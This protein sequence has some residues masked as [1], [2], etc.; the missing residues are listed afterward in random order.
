MLNVNQKKAL[1]EMLAPGSRTADEVA[2]AA[3]LSV[4][5]VYNY[6]ANDEFRAALDQRLDHSIS[7]ATV[8]LTQLSEKAINAL[9]EI[10]D[11]K[12]ASDTNK[13]LAAVAAL[14]AMLRVQ[15]LRNLMGRMARIEKEIAEIKGR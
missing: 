6:L 11:N 10:L 7:S 4:S 12:D 1:K 14:D 8:R 3:G 2:A 5:T 15:D 9:E 13:R